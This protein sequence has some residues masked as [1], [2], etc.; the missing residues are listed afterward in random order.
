MLNST[1]YMPINFHKYG[2][3][4]LTFI[5]SAHTSDTMTIQTQNPDSRRLIEVMVDNI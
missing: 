3:N 1:K 2:V 5:K 4:T